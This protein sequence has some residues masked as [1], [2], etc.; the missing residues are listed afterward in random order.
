MCAGGQVIHQVFFN[1]FD[2]H[3][4]IVNL[5]SRFVFYVD[6]SFQI[7]D[8]IF[9]T[10]KNPAT[11]QAETNVWSVVKILNIEQE[12]DQTAG[13]YVTITLQQHVNYQS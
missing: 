10:K 1:Q 12:W 3:D 6:R 5:K 11:R 2:M 7:G 9:L 13:N 4:L 8:F